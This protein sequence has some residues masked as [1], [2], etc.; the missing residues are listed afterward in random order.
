MGMPL[1]NA[2]QLTAITGTH[3]GD[4]RRSQAPELAGSLARALPGVLSSPVM[5]QKPDAGQLR[6]ERDERLLDG[7]TTESLLAAAMVKDT[8]PMLSERLAALFRRRPEAAAARAL[9][10]AT[11]PEIDGL[12]GA[13]I[14]SDGDAGV[15]AAAI[16]AAGFR[17]PIGPQI[18]QALVRAAKA[19]PAESVRS[20]AIT[21]LRENPGASPETAE[22]LA[23]IAGHDAKPGVRRL[24]QEALTSMEK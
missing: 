6:D 21:L 3:L 17:H 13:A 14:T 19:D 16:F 12:L 2:G 1:A 15:R 8:E 24:A 23:W 11:G 20:G 18:G 22:T 7:R 4:L 10:L 9:R 5:T